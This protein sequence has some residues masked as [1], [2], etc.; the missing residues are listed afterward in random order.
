MLY[1]HLGRASLEAGKMAEQPYKRPP[2]TEAVIA[3]TFSEA[4]EARDLDKADSNFGRLYPHHQDA[5]NLNVQVLMPP[6]SNLQPDTTINKD[7]IGHRRSSDDQTQIVILWPTLF[8]FSQLAPYPGWDDFLGRFV[9][10]WA[11]LKKIVGYRKISRVGVRYINRIDIPITGEVTHYEEFLN[12]YPQIPDKLGPVF[13]YGIQTQLS[14]PEIDGRITIN[15][16]SVPSPLLDNASFI[17]DQDLY[18]ESNIPQVEEG[19]YKLLNEIH[20]K[21]N[22]VFEACITDRARELFNA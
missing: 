15:S 10:D 19:L 1:R 4:I 3:L 7:E 2:I 21:K 11:L 18:K 6:T 16:A 8:V 14:F 13:A 20:V 22:A 5:R 12:L 17:F 9:R